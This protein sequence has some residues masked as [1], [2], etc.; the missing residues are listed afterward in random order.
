V[1]DLKEITKRF[2]KEMQREYGYTLPPGFVEVEVVNVGIT[3]LGKVRKPEL[4]KVS[5]KGTLKE[6][7]KEKR[8]VYFHEAGGFTET[9]IYE[10]SKLPSN[11]SFDGPAIVEQPDTTTV[12]PPASVGVIDDYGN[13]VIRIK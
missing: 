9:A 7:L 10:R 4:A 2:L 3:A 11:T 1:K 5:K 6:A 12:M 8:Q 13:L